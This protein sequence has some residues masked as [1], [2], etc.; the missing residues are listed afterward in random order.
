MFVHHDRQH[1]ETSN[2]IKD[3]HMSTVH[4]IELFVRHL[5]TA[6]KAVKQIHPTAL[7]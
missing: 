3:I 2:N 5:R 1:V 6:Q 4:I 7:T